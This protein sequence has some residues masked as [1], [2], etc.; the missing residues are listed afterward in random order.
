MIPSEAQKPTY[1]RSI[2]RGGVVRRE[3]PK[4]SNQNINPRP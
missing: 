4:Y 2:E 3:E 1:N